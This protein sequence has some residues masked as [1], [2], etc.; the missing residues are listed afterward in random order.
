M[1]AMIIAILGLL[2]G[3]NLAFFWPGKIVRRARTESAYFLEAEFS[4]PFSAAFL[5]LTVV[6][7]HTNV[8]ILYQR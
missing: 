4:G 7:L 5:F 1:R 3:I 6:L 2:G 8:Q